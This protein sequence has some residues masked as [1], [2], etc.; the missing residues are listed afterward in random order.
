MKIRHQFSFVSLQGR[1]DTLR[2]R[3]SRVICVD[4]N[5]R[6]PIWQELLPR[7]MSFWVYVNAYEKLGV[8]LGLVDYP[9]NVFP[10][11]WYEVPVHC[12]DVNGEMADC[13]GGVIHKAEAPDIKVNMTLSSEVMVSAT[14]VPC[15]S[16]AAVLQVANVVVQCCWENIL[17][18]S[19][20]SEVEDM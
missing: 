16:A 19:E 20:G 3:D 11:P 13:S 6:R 4:Q 1:H 5:V 18:L 17:R 8:L 14:L 9:S 2:L 7:M 12:G 15:A 10:L